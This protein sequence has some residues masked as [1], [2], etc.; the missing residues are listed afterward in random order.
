MDKQLIVVVEIPRYIRQVQISGPQIAQ[1]YRQDKKLP[2]K[3]ASKLAIEYQ[4]VKFSNLK[5]PILCNANK[6]PVIKNEK[7][8]GKPTFKLIRGQELHMLTL[9]DYERS[10]II[11]AIKEQMVQYTNKLEPIYDY[12]LVIECEL[13]DT[14]SDE[15]LKS[16]KGNIRDINFDIDNRFLFYGKTFP[17]VLGGCPYMDED[18]GEMVCKSKPIIVDDHRLYITGPPSVLFCPISNSKDRKLVFRI[19]QDK[20][21]IIRNNSNYESRN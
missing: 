17:D 19:Y 6:K 8:I 1:Y 15:E 3:Y 16:T 7:D 11:T 12:P 4:W 20:R 9:Q 14:F 13:Y 5:Y 18:T 21:E 2:V 10:K